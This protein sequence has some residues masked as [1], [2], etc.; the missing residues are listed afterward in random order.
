MPF[1]KKST[2]KMTYVERWA[3][4]PSQAECWCHDHEWRPLEGLHATMFSNR[5]RPF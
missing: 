5:F 4:F 3:G 1:A 2:W